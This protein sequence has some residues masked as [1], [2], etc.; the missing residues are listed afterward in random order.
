MRLGVCRLSL[1]LPVE[2]GGTGKSLQEGSVGSGSRACSEE[3]PCGRTAGHLASGS[4]LERQPGCQPFKAGT[5]VFPWSPVGAVCSLL[6][7]AQDVGPT[8]EETSQKNGIIEINLN[9][10]SNIITTNGLRALIKILILSNW[11]KEKQSP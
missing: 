4:R 8:T 6:C 5:L 2:A 10:S 3:D 7:S 9:K 1:G 11:I